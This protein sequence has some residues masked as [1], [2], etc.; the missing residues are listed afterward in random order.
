MQ[1]TTEEIEDWVPQ[2]YTIP[3]YVEK[4]ILFEVRYRVLEVSLVVV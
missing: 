1:E 2:I 4:I 3:D